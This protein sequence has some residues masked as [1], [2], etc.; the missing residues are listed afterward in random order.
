MSANSK[1]APTTGADE[2]VDSPLK[3][4]KKAYEKRL[5]DLQAQLV[6]MQQWVR[7]TG[8]RVVIIMEGTRRRGKGLRDQAHHPVPQPAVLP[9]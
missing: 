6:E 9:G 8:A 2:A 5:E 4:D 3:L 1:N 7:E